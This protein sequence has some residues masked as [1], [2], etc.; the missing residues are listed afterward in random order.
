MGGGGAE[1]VDLADRQKKE[2]VTDK[3]GGLAGAA[4]R[5]MVEGQSPEFRYAI[6][7]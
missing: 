1:K 3:P 5:E 6:R 7:E 2:V 4:E